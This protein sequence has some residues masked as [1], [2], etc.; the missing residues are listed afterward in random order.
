[1][2]T[3]TPAECLLLKLMVANNVD[4]ALENVLGAFS[5]D[6]PGAWRPGWDPEDTADL[7]LFTPISRQM[8]FVMRTLMP[9]LLVL[10]MLVSGLFPGARVEVK[11][12]PLGMTPPGF[13][14]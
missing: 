12:W 5:L 13:F 14:R 1:M 7:R 11:I 2:V 6:T 10:L 9:W 8:V 4:A 3:G